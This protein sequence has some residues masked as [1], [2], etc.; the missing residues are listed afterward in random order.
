MLV[1]VKVIW[2]VNTV[3]SGKF[4]QHLPPECW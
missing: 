4:L 3:S 2:D 1:K